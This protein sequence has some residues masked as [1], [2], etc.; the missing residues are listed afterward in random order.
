MAHLECCHDPGEF[1]FHKH[2]NKNCWKCAVCCHLAQ[3]GSS[4]VL[5]LMGVTN[6]T[7]NNNNSNNN[8][9]QIGI[10]AHKPRR[11]QK[12]PSKFD[13]DAFECEPKF[14]PAAREE[15]KEETKKKMKKSL[16]VPKVYDFFPKCI[17]CPH[18]GGVMSRIPTSSSIGERCPDNKDDDG[19]NNKSNANDCD[20]AHDVCR[21]WCTP[22]PAA[23]GD[24]AN[25]VSKQN[26]CAICGNNNGKKGNRKE[27][28]SL[29]SSGLI[30][31]AARGCQVH[32]HPF[33]ALLASKL[34]DDD[35]SSSNSKSNDAHLVTQYTLD[36]LEV[37]HPDNDNNNN[38]AVVGVV[39][40][41]YCGLHN[42]HRDA[43][44]Y[45]LGGV[46]CEAMRIPSASTEQF[47][48]GG[49]G[50]PS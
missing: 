5:S 31:C 37:E 1:K 42:P 22:L 2:K 45:G 20:W 19:S 3:N 25:C 10:A 27:S 15:K 41:G 18:S 7:A 13:D 38:S 21:T 44:Y 8:N 4:K 16:H 26:V 30:K 11:S 40:V 23:A 29:L 9:Q 47:N 24:A 36:M 28:S 48:A 33:C 43:E 32:F 12:R 17:F 46:I 14:L 39:P 34:I 49:F 35:D 6:G 50:V